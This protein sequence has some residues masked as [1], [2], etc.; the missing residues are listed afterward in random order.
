[1]SASIVIVGGSGHQGSRAAQALLQEGHEVIVADRRPPT[2]MG[3]AFAEADATDVASIERVAHGADVVMNFAGPY[4]ALGS[5]VAQAAANLGKP[6]VDICDDAEATE[7]LLG[8]DVDARASG[9]AIVIGAGSSPG[10][11]NGIALRV[12]EGFDEL[13]ELVLAWVVGERGEAGAAPLQHFF[14]GISRE[15]PIWRDGARAMVPAFDVDSAEEFPFQEPVGPMV[16]R[17][18]GHPETVTLPR[19]LKVGTVRNKGALLPRRSTEIYDLLRRIGLTSDRTVEVA[20]VPVVARDFVAQLLTDRHNEHGG[21]A[22][23]DVMG[24]GV[25]ASGTSGGRAVRRYVSS[26]GRIAMTDTTALPAAAAV[27]LLLAGDVPPGAHGPE[28]LEPAAWF[29]ELDRIAPDIYNDIEVWEDD[30]PRVPTSLV[31]LGRVRDVAEL[32]AASA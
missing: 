21:D 8:L 10:L 28:A 23:D 13:D 26:A 11:L 16:V 22:A 7:E 20:G 17:D 24:L 25:R 1:M 32:L 30:G 18:V 27:A 12:A 31:E 19:V 5:T 9:A 15:I 2:V 6:Y 29:A 14:Y 4:Y 3:A